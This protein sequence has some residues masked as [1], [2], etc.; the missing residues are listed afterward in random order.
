[1]CNAISSSVADFALRADNVLRETDERGAGQE[2][3]NPEHEHHRTEEHGRSFLRVASG[4]LGQLQLW[5]KAKPLELGCR[6]PLLAPDSKVH[7]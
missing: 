4:D 3:R 1:M 2:K 7:P 6:R 5:E